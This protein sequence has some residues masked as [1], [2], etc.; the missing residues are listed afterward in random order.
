M[1]SFILNSQVI[2]S[3]GVYRECCSCKK[4]WQ[5]SYRVG[6]PL[7]IQVQQYYN[8]GMK[9][10]WKTFSSEEYKLHTGQGS[11]SEL[12]QIKLAMS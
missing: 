11:V 2:D 7:D 4:D 9:I 12:R 8:K 6:Y 3:V 10:K 1:F 5:W